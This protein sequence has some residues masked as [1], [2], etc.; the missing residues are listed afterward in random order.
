M[1]GRR[2]GDAGKASRGPHGRKVGFSPDQPAGSQQSAAALLYLCSQSQGRG[3][4][5]VGIGAVPGGAGI[6]VGAFW[7]DSGWGLGPQ[8]STCG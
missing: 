3:G 7:G 4:F 5:R 6:L 2:Q 8:A 1:Q